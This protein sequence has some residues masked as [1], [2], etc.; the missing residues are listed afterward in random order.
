MEG[1]FVTEKIIFAQN[2]PEATARRL[3]VRPATAP[4][5]VGVEARRGSR[6]TDIGAVLESADGLPG[7]TVMSA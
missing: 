4:E 1:E 2:F 5:S 7:P 3:A 6:V